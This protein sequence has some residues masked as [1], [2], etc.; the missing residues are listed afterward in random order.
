MFQ[1]R[2][3]HIAALL[4][5]AGLSACGSYRGEW[6]KLAPNDESD[7]AFQ[8]EGQIEQAA[9]EISTERPTISDEESAARL[10]N[11]NARL[12]QARANFSG[13]LASY[14]MQKEAVESARKKASSGRLGPSSTD[15]AT[16]QLEL[17]RLEQV[18]TEIKGL[19]SIVA[20]ISADIASTSAQ[21]ADVS[22]ALQRA[23]EL[24]AQIDKTLN[25]ADVYRREVN[26]S[27]SD[28]PR[29]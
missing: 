11:L 22:G 2:A 5:L 8:R 14:D 17:T 4:A 13:A 3:T 6:P 26:M 25:S 21:G 18:T 29:P 23:G 9:Q 7:T 27:L 10:E 1:F 28:S 12:T 20:R 16:T 15:W 19:R 24:V